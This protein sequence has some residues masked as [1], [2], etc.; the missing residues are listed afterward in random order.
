MKSR[1]PSVS[2]QRHPTH[3]GFLFGRHQRAR[4]TREFAGAGEGA[5]IEQVLQARL[6]R[7]GRS[8]STGP[9]LVYQEKDSVNTMGVTS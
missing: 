6:C 8:T 4:P 7:S 5:E 1:R 9:N 3:N 2:G